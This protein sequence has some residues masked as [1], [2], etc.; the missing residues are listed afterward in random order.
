[1]E[2]LRRLALK[3]VADELEDPPDHEKRQGVEPQAMEEEAGNE[4]CDR[5]ENGRNAE[6]VADPVDG[7]LVAARV[8]R[9][10]LLA[11]AVA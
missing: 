3:G 5:D 10:P 6:R 9:D 2:E 8:L 11:G 1:M 7:M 4:N